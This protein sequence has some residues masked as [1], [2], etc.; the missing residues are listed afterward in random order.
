M[1]DSQTNE[2]QVAEAEADQR[3]SAALKALRGSGDVEGEAEADAEA[4]AATEAAEATE[5]TKQEE[6]PEEA[7]AASEGEGDSEGAEEDEDAGDALLDVLS[8]PDTDRRRRN[9]EER[10]AKRDEIQTEAEG[11]DL[12]AGIAK[13]L[14]A[15]VS[16]SEAKDFLDRWRELR[17]AR[18]AGQTRTD[19]EAAAAAAPSQTS[20]SEVRDLIGEG[21][22]EETA[23]AVAGL[24]GRLEGRIAELEG[25]TFEAIRQTKRREAA[26]LIKEAADGLRK[27]FPKLVRGDRVDPAV[28]KHTA[29]LMRG[30]E[31]TLSEAMEAAARSVFGRGQ[32]SRQ[33][34]K[35]PDLDAPG[36]AQNLPG[37]V[38][39]DRAKYERVRAVQIK[40][41]NAPNVLELMSKERARI[42]RHNAAILRQQRGR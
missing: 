16:E 33:D 13:A 9:R 29:A 31:Y 42:D 23:E 3:F 4:A 26:V 17:Q 15:N 36:P 2:D 20:A 37:E 11:L 21:A 19:D 40:H 10:L 6:A 24:I 39:N 30:G 38:I 25:T 12:P 27:Q 41:R 14:G 7:P 8:E 18:D 34:N 5:D 1:A 35:S 28:R 22:S 32:A